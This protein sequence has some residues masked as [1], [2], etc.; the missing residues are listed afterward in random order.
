MEKTRSLGERAVVAITVVAT[1]VCLV[2]T[3]VL[4]S[5]P[6]ASWAFYMTAGSLAVVFIVCIIGAEIY[7]FNHLVTGVYLANCP[8]C[9]AP[10]GQPKPRP[11]IPQPKHPLQPT[12]KTEGYDPDEIKRR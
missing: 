11:P 12:L 6:M 10:Y 3:I 1:I 5:T 9:G 8:H 7:D 2:G 4:L